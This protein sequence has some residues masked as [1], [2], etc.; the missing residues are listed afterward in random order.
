MF[1]HAWPKAPL[2]H[3]VSLEHAISYGEGMAAEDIELLRVKTINTFASASA[4][5]AA[6]AAANAAN[7]AA[8]VANDAVDVVDV[9][10]AATSAYAAA[11]TADAACA[12]A[13]AAVRAGDATV[14]FTTA[15]AA[16]EAATAATDV[17]AADPQPMVIAIRH[18]FELLR[19]AV[20]A[21]GWNDDTPVPPE[22]FGPLWPWGEPE[23]WPAESQT[24]E[25]YSPTLR[26]EFTVPAEVDRER[27]DAII[28]DILVRASE[29]HVAL[30]GTGLVIKQAKVYETAGVP[31]PSGVG[32]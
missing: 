19:A 4:D 27:V 9:G 5:A 18:D 25:H 16:F 12:A 3:R 29:L 22:F 11:R 10:D 7:A 6:H 26:V 14:D 8:D 20:A 21:E 15:D 23:G 32:P 13:H 2:R 17:A 30:G 1:P 24:T 31:E 28:A